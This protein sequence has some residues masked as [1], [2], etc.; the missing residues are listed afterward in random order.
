MGWRGLEEQLERGEDGRVREKK[1]ESQPSMVLL[2]LLMGVC[3]LPGLLR[4]MGVLR[5]DGKVNGS[6]ASVSMRLPRETRVCGEGLRER[7][8][9]RAALC[10]GEG[11]LPSVDMD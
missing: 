8:G 3:G 2:R 7:F 6:S 1:G 9:K 4:R 11:L 10:C 5:A